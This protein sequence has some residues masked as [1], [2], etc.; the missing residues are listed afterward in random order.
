MN[1]TTQS[2]ATKDKTKIRQLTEQR[3]NHEWQLVHE[4]LTVD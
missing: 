3:I 2:Q 4:H 1:I